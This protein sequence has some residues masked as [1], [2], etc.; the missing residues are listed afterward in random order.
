[1]KMINIKNFP[2]ISYKQKMEV[3]TGIRPFRKGGIRI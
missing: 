3:L 2:E 1:M